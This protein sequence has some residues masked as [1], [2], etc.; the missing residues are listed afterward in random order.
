MIYKLSIKDPAKTPVRWLAKVD[1]IQQQRVFEFR[2]GLNILWG[3]NGSGKTSLTKVL[4]RLFHCEQ[5]NHP[6]VTEE[7]LRQLTGDGTLEAA[8]I[9][10]G[11]Q[12]V[13]DGQGVRHFDP[14][15][16]VGLMGGLAAFDWDFGAEGISNAMFKGSAGQTTMF[17]FDRIAEEIVASEVPKVAWK[18]PRDRAAKDTLGQRVA[19]AA[20]LLESNAEKG[21]PTILLDEPERSYDLNTQIGI[22]RFLRAYSDQVQF[23][24]ASH[25]LFALKIPEAHYIELSPG[26]LEGAEKALE[27][28]QKWSAEKPPKVSREKTAIAQRNAK[29]RREKKLRGD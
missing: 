17:R 6:L 26:Y 22:W 12:V 3:R 24:V 20:H 10:K 23:I 1:A 18:F 13:H 27:V 14:G 5:G 19:L 16:A 28:L 29:A 4:A 15:S 7:S 2:P 25:S 9:R 11:L 8:D 21:P